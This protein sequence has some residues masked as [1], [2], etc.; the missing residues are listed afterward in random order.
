MARALAQ[1]NGFS[2]AGSQKDHSIHVALRI[3]TLSVKVSCVRLINSK[4]INVI[5]IIFLVAISATKSLKLVN[6]KK[7]DAIICSICFDHL[8]N[9]LVQTTVNLCV[10]CAITLTVEKLIEFPIVC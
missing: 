1:A 8:K 3:S 7:N 2:I 9:A 10:S 6:I 5:V 4:H